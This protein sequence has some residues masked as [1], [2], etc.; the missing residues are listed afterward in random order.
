MG[1]IA[2]VPCLS[3]AIATRSHT[4]RGT[5]AETDSG[6]TAATKPAG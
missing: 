2:A 3:A 5:R 1:L 6:F 4:S